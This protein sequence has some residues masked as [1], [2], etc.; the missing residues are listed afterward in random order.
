MFQGT[1]TLLKATMSRDF[2]SAVFHQTTFP[3]GHRTIDMPTAKKG[4]RISSNIHGIIRIRNR[5]P[6]VFTT[7]ESTSTVL[8]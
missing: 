4:F 1:Q 3:V 7:G 6:G 8:I 2:W 5:L